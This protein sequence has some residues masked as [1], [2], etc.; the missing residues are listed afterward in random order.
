MPL[1]KGVVPVSSPLGHSCFNFWKVQLCSVCSVSFLFL[2][3]QLVWKARAPT[4]T[5]VRATPGFRNF[6][7]ETHCLPWL[8]SDTACLARVTEGLWGS[9][10]VHNDDDD[11]DKVWLVAKTLHKKVVLKLLFPN[12]KREAM[13]KKN[14]D[15]DKQMRVCPLHN[16]QALQVP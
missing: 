16:L 5:L 12:G 3:L 8:P 6:I 13:Q 10:A 14:I 7:S 15:K 2:S 1:K 4:N 9:A 11:N